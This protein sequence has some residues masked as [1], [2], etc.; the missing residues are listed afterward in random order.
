MFSNVDQIAMRI[1]SSADFLRNM[2]QVIHQEERFNSDLLNAA[3]RGLLSNE[4][5]TVEFTER[6]KTALASDI[7]DQVHRLLEQSTDHIRNEVQNHLENRYVQRL[8][9]MEQIVNPMQSMLRNTFG[10]EVSDLRNNE[11]SRVLDAQEQRIRELVSRIENAAALQERLN[12]AL[13]QPIVMTEPVAAPRRTRS[14]TPRMSTVA[15]VEWPDQDRLTRLMAE[16]ATTFRETAAERLFEGICSGLATRF[17]GVL[18]REDSRCTTANSVG[19]TGAYAVEGAPPVAQRSDFD[20]YWI[21]IGNAA[22][23]P[24]REVA[25]DLFAIRNA[26]HQSPE[27]Y[28]VRFP[29]H[30]QNS[31]SLRQMLAAAASMHP[32][33]RLIDFSNHCSQTININNYRILPGSWTG[34]WWDLG[35]R[36]QQRVN[37]RTL[38]VRHFVNPGDSD[39]IVTMDELVLPPGALDLPL[40]VMMQVMIRQLP[41]ADRLMPAAEVAAAAAD[42]TNNDLPAAAPV[43]MDEATPPD[44]G[45]DDPEYNVEDDEEYDEDDD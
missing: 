14:S 35:F 26:A 40:G 41:W 3:V 1:A 29:L 31:A 17:R 9:E 8:A 22:V 45:E 18:A 43:R 19:K 36:S 44:V 6:M 39:H 5:V 12:G 24:L 23:A 4:N 28:W 34:F 38:G 33:A 13:L 32:A 25:L 27:D 15:A 42:P 37:G 10:Q 7:N 30:A 20:R 11:A 16:R 21:H 2:C